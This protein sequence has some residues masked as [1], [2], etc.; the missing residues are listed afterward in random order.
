MVGAINALAAWDA[1]ANADVFTAATKIVDR[2]GQIKRAAE[3]AL[4]K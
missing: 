2:R 4:A 1:K 3:K